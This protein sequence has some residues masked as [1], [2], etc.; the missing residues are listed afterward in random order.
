MGCIE[1][2]MPSSLCGCEA[3]TRAEHEICFRNYK[4][5]YFKTEMLLTWCSL[6]SKWCPSA[7]PLDWCWYLQTCLSWSRLAVTSYVDFCNIMRTYSQLKLMPRMY[8]ASFNMKACTYERGVLTLME[9]IIYWEGMACRMA[10][11]SL[12]QNDRTPLLGLCSCLSLMDE[13][14]LV[15]LI[16]EWQCD[17]RLF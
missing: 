12:R 5:I 1:I 9:L 15:D 10:P 8:S 4:L 11:C 2:A 14:F 7:L 13:F 16:C 3:Q 6:P 17:S